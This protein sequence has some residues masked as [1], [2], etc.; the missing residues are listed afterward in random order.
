MISAKSQY[1]SD[2]VISKNYTAYNGT[3]MSA[4]VVTGTI[5]LILQLRPEISFEELLALFQ[6]I[7]P[8]SEDE[9]TGELPNNDFGYGKLNMNT[10]YEELIISNVEEYF[11]DR[12]NI[13]LY[14]NPSE[15][16]ICVD[17]IDAS[18]EYM[19][20]DLSGNLL[21][22]GT[23][24]GSINIEELPSGRYFLNLRNSK[25]AYAIPFSKVK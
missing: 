6:K 15:D 19:L 22:T 25:Q 8:L 21:K 20:F 13:T 4:P 12:P 23:Y 3:S 11:I 1:T 9:L 2:E 10:I 16:Y 5:A 24:T 7:A 17:G 18:W 14:P